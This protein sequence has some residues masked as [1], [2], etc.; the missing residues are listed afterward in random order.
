MQNTAEDIS[1]A[2]TG[3]K[4]NLSN[5]STFPSQGQPSF[6]PLPFHQ[7]TNSLS[8]TSEASKENSRKELEKLGGEDAFYG[9]DKKGD[10]APDAGLGNPGNIAGGH[11][12]AIANDGTFL[13]LRA[14]LKP[15]TCVDLG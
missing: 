15:A 7:R 2:A 3:H 14:S 5:P 1:H 4:A 13:A 11:K 9:K 12:A 10:A 8:D 6:H